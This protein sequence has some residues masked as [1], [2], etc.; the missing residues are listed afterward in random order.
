[1]TRTQRRRSKQSTTE[2]KSRLLEE[3]LKKRSVEANLKLQVKKSK[4]LKELHLQEKDKFAQE[5]SKLSS[6]V[7]ALY[8]K[9]PSESSENSYKSLEWDDAEESPPS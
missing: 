7:D 4:S 9:T 2:V 6:T 1:M 5:A 3:K 8:P